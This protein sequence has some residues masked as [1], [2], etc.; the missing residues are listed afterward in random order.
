MAKYQPKEKFQRELGKRIR[1]IRR[2]K[3]ISLKEM[4]ARD[5][6]MDKS[7]LS[8]I[9]QGKYIPELY[10]LYKIASLLEEDIAEFFKK[11]K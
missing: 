4:E 7:H 11:E 1:Q 3:G 2:S 8:K 10:T 9:E 6:S 5:D